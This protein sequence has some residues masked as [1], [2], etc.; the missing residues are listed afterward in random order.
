MENPRVESGRTSIFLLSNTWSSSSPYA[1]SYPGWP[2]MNTDNNSTA[3]LSQPQQTSQQFQGK[4]WTVDDNGW[5]IQAPA[6]PWRCGVCARDN[7]A[8][9]KV[10][11]QCNALRAWAS[12]TNPAQSSSCTSQPQPPVN[13]TR[14]MQTRQQLSQVTS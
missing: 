1:A 6:Q 4:V 12:K 13:A 14:G 10:Y 3:H 7:M 8:R 11:A 2:G 5:W 9:A